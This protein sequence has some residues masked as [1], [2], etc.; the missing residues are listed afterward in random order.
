MYIIKV[1]VEFP[2]RGNSFLNLWLQFFDSVVFAVCILISGLLK[3]RLHGW[4]EVFLVFLS[5]VERRMVSNRALF[6]GSR[7]Q[8]SALKLALSTE[9]FCTDPG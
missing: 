6:G 8:N 4:L 7:V 3:C 1:H 5:V 2:Y 9:F